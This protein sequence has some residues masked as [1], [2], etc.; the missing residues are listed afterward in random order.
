VFVRLVNETYEEQ[1][2][3]IECPVAFVWGQQDTAAP[4]AIAEAAREMVGRLASF[5]VVDA[6]HDVHR[7]HAEAYARAIAAVEAAP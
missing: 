1:L 4:V 7:A 3:T 2:R 5:E 6:G